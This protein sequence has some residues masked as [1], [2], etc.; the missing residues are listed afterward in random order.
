MWGGWGGWGAYVGGRIYVYIYGDMYTHSCLL[1]YACVD[2]YIYIYIGSTPSRVYSN[3]SHIGSTP[4]R[5]YSNPKPCLL[6]SLMN[7]RSQTPSRVYSNQPYFVFL[8]D[9]YPFYVCLTFYFY[10]Y[11]FVYFLPSRHS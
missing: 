3:P 2:T 6:K 8:F 11:L 5:V 4:S 7:P 1:T 9:C 10:L